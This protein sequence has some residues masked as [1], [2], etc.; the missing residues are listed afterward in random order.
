[1]QG[2]LFVSLCF[3][4][5][6]FIREELC[7]SWERLQLLS[8]IKTVQDGLS[9]ASHGKMVML[10]LLLTTFGRTRPVKQV[11]VMGSSGY[12]QAEST[13]R[14]FQIFQIINASTHK[15]V[16]VCGEVFN[17]YWECSKC[18]SSFKSFRDEWHFSMFPLSHVIVL[19]QKAG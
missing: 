11:F 8:S 6:E 9:V 15:L 13:Q 2:S 16:C 14:R 10:L 19:Q 4:W 18:P 1:M 17:S 7:L 12:T 3:N 5:S